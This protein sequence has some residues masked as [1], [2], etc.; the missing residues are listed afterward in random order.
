M[1]ERR[2][3]RVNVES[4]PA[5]HALQEEA[6]REL[7]INQQDV[8]IPDLTSSQVRQVGQLMKQKI[9]DAAQSS[10]SDHE[11]DNPPMAR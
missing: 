2:D 7:G 8:S 9:A 6:M 4:M 3:V 5:M 10:T 1:T 11:V